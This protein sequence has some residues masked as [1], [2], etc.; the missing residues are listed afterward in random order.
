MQN[1][2]VSSPVKSFVFRDQT[3]RQVVEQDIP[4]IRTLVNS[5]YKELADMGLNYTATYQDEKLTRERVAKGRAFALEKDGRIIGT[6]LL[7]QK[8]YFTGRKSAYV[9]QLAI[10]PELKKSGLGNLLMDLCEA[11]ARN[12]G[13]DSIQL[14]TAKPAKHL[15]SW[16][17]RRGYQII[18]ATQWDGK[19]YESWIFEKSLPKNTSH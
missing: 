12:E 11:I 19:T 5:A 4:Q 18:G 17:L 6:V 16:Y 7:R 3:I 13:F 9:S 14:D 2:E 15:V 1:T 10:L 8:N